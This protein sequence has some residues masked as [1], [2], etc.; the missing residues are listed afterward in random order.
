VLAA[1]ELKVFVIWRFINKSISVGSYGAASAI[2]GLT[3]KATT[4]EGDI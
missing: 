4:L 3:G 2:A 1:H